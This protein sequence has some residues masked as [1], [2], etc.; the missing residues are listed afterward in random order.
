MIHCHAAV[1]HAESHTVAASADLILVIIGPR[2]A[3]NQPSK[4]FE[5]LCHSKPI[6]ALGPNGNPIQAILA[7]L[8]IGIYCD[9][10]DADSIENGIHKLANNYEDYVKNFEI[11]HDQIAI[12]SASRVAEHWGYCLDSMLKWSKEHSE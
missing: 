1:S 8:P 5:Y 12:Y 6:L 11:Y 7:K 10:S 9:I 4:F 2:H 3:D